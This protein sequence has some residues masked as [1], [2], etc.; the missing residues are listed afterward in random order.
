M[1]AQR[2]NNQS[3][4]KPRKPLNKAKKDNQAEYIMPLPKS[5]PF[6]EAFEKRFNRKVQRSD[7]RM[8]LVNYEKNWILRMTL[9]GISG[10]ESRYL[11]Y[12]ARKYNSFILNQI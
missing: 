1:S 4:S 5:L 7:E 3:F 9:G 6:I 12:L 8:L 2:K 10:E 11:R